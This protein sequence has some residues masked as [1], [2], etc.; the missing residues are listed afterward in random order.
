[1]DARQRKANARLGLVLAGIALAVA[2]GFVVRV[3]TLPR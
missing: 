3:L 2:V 1:M